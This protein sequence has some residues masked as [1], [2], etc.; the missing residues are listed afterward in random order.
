MSS[1]LSTSGSSLPSAPGG[2]GDGF[3]RAADRQRTSQQPRQAPSTLRA[4]AGDGRGLTFLLYAA[5]QT[6]TWRAPPATAGRALWGASSGTSFLS[7]LLNP[8]RLSRRAAPLTFRAVA[9]QIGHHATAL[10]FSGRYDVCQPRSR[11]RNS[12]DTSMSRCGTE[13]TQTSRSGSLRRLL[14]APRPSPNR[15]DAG[16]SG[17]G[18]DCGGLRPAAFPDLVFTPELIIAEGDLVAA[19]RSDSVGNAPRSLGRRRADRQAR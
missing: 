15:I 17:T 8:R 2:P 7:W 14:R 16:R 18:E 3:R 9:F 6:G 4:A 12:Y 10:R 5:P 13:E 19:A 11:T 1:S